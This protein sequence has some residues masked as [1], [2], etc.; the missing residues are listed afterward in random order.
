[1]DTSQIQDLILTSADFALLSLYHLIDSNDGIIAIQWSD[2]TAY[3]LAYKGCISGLHNLCWKTSMS[4]VTVCRMHTYRRSAMQC[5][6]PF[7]WPPMPQSSWFSWK[8]LSLR[9][10]VHMSFC[11]RGLNTKCYHLV[12]S[13]AGSSAL[14]A[15]C[16]QAPQHN[17]IP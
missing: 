2:I 15:C 12:R 7:Q 5:V 14:S 13:R 17:C 11:T 9:S 6:H 16:G 8:H 10:F 4:S 1:M 3:L